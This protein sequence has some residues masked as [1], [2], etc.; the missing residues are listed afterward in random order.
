MSRKISAVINTLN[1]AETLERALKSLSWADEILVCDMYSSD[2]TVE[3]AK[4][5]GARVIKHEK[6]SFVEP[7]RNFAISKAEHDWVLILDPDEEISESLSKKLREIANSDGVTTHVE[8]PRKNMIF[9]K[10][11][12]GSMWWPDYNIRFFKKNSVKW[13]D[14]IHRPP[15][16][17]GQGIKLSDEERFAITHYHYS[18]V[19]QF[20]HKLDRYSSV[21]AKELYSEGVRF[22]LADLVHKPLNEFLSRFF[23]LK[24]YQDGLHGLVLGI[25]QA[26]SFLVVY[27]K[28]WELEGF[29]QKDINMKELKGITDRAGKDLAYWFSFVSLSHNPV[30]RLLQKAKSKIS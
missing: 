1:E 30:K 16:T 28:L 24:G 15:L 5:L 22:K 11:V 21:Q 4:K 10:W 18:S 20:M 25:L 7:A 29:E 8:I 2:E 3:I 17:E 14:K 26:I 23:A 19:S 27:I 9:G 6:L 13:S 12:K